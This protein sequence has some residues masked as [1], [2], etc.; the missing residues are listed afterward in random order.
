MIE[1]YYPSCPFFNTKEI[2]IY[3]LL[4]DIRIVCP[5]KTCSQ[6]ST[7][8]QCSGKVRNY[9]SDNKLI[10]ENQIGTTQGS[11]RTLFN[12]LVSLFSNLRKEALSEKELRLNWTLFFELIFEASSCILISIINNYRIILIPC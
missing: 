1:N 10:K 3:I 9:V 4:V 12:L 7:N 8:S 11:T 5:I 6:L 2:Y